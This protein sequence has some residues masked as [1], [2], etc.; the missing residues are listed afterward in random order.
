MAIAPTLAVLLVFQVVR[1]AVDY[2]IARPARE[3]LFTVL[4]RDAKYKSKNFIDTVV[5]RGGDAA[6]GWLYGGFKALGLALPGMA[7]A[8]IPGVLL[9]LGLGIF[10]GRRYRDLARAP[11]PLS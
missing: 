10:L 6:S 8:A 7:V 11:R 5:F 1:R 4:G 9:W 3:M 2:A